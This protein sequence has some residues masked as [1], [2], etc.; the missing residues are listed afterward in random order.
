MKHPWYL[1]VLLGAI[2]VSL[3]FGG[4]AFA[5]E[6]D[7][8]VTKKG[9]IFIP[10]G[11]FKMGSTGEEGRVGMSVG[12]DELPQHTVELKG[13]YI[14]QFELTNRKYKEFVDAARYLSPR[15]P[16]EGKYSWKDNFPPP[17]QE[18]LPV[19]YVSWYD[20]D[21]YCKW[22]GKRLPTE[23]EWEKAARGT[24]GRQWPWGNVFNEVACNTK[25]LG[26]GEI[27]SVGKRPDDRSPYAVYDMCGNVSEWTSSWYQP[28]PGS[29]LQRESYGE[30]SRITRGGSWVMPYIPYS[31]AAYRANSYKPEYK[32]RG[33]GF[34]CVKDADEKS[35]II[36]QKAE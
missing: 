12:V 22:A 7:L 18:D 23:S 25:Y 26:T 36:K 8:L 29:T 28:Y 24:D 27:Q 20:A 35:E 5:V 9:M 30:I 6:E 14:D 32:H 2:T 34:R 17:G 4:H 11:P 33:I 31:R 10:P 19:T 13:F 1:S 15:D 21:A 16:Y 3:F